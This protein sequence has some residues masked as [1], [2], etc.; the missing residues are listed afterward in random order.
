MTLFKMPSAHPTGFVS[1]VASLVGAGLFGFCDVRPLYVTVD[2]CI[3]GYVV[4]CVR[5]VC[6]WFRLLLCN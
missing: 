1:I 5:V 4:D 2:D 3:K 6:S